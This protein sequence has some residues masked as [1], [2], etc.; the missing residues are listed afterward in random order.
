MTYPLATIGAL[1]RRPDGR[2]LLIRTHKWLETWGVP[3]GKIDYG[4]TMKGALE[5]EFL[6]ET[7]L[8]LTHI[9]W[10]PVQ[11]AVQSPEFYKDAH[12]ILLNFVALTDD[13]SVTLNDEAQG[14]VWTT[15]EDALTYDLNTPTRR[16]LEFYL[17]HLPLEG[18]LSCL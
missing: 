8:N 17:A 18:K 7:G 9:Y 15:P 5:R 3:G 10:G 12:F 16:L 13:T 4:E 11:E 14:H 1:V 2:V 6:E